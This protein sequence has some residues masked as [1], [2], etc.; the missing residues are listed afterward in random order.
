MDHDTPH[1]ATLRL[2]SIR[3]AYR[4][5]GAGGPVV[6]LL[7]GWPQ[8]SWAWRRVMPLLGTSFDVV[9]PD[10]P[11]FGDSGKPDGGFDKKTIALRLHELVQALGL[12]RIALVGHDMGGQVAY[13]YAAQ[14]PDEVSHLVF[15][16]SGLPG[17]GQEKAMNVAE[18]GSWHF[19]FNMAGD[20]AEALV[21]GREGVFV[22]YLM[23]RDTVGLYD[24]D[25]VSAAGVKRYADALARPGALRCS[26][27]YYRALPVDRRDNVAWGQT[28]LAMPVLAVGAEAGYGGASA[29]T[30]RR[31]AHNVSA[32]LVERCGHYVPEEQPAVLAR[33]IADFLTV[34]SGGG[35]D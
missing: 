32:V 21:Q 15:I 3:L 25:S 9:A 5:T 22:D 12:S 2:G 19:G 28:P 16:E 6:L 20:I 13:A 10:M 11:G 27:G 33:A 4:R 30:M 1:A 31:V 14:W 7:H 8:T 24:P 23:R 29:E 18:G 34:G 35:P 17:F 26:F